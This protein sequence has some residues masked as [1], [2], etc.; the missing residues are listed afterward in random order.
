VSVE[1]V[2]SIGRLQIVV[3]NVTD[4]LFVM[5]GEAAAGLANIFLIACYAG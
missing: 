2:K 5:E 1:N 3:F 4:V